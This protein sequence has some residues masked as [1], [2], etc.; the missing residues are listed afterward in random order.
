M[1][2]KILDRL[3]WGRNGWPRSYIGCHANGIRSDPW[4]ARNALGRKVR[5]ICEIVGH[6]P[7]GRLQPAWST[8]GPFII[9]PGDPRTA[10]YTAYDWTNAKGEVRHVEGC[11]QPHCGIVYFFRECSRCKKRCP[12]SE[13]S[14]A[15]KEAKTAEIAAVMN[16]ARAQY[17][18][19]P[20]SW[21]Q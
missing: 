16:G 11:I 12:E 19:H 13:K 9:P 21:D 6:D 8:S 2:G 17:G 14:R 15:N 4:I 1:I 20:I 5:F 18:L 10:D 3:I 7:Q